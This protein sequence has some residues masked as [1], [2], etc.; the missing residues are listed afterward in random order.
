MQAARSACQTPSLA[1]PPQAQE[2]NTC[3][4]SK[5]RV[6]M[7]AAPHAAS[8]LTPEVPC[9]VLRCVEREQRR[10]HQRGCHERGQRG[11]DAFPAAGLLERTQAGALGDALAAGA[12]QV[13]GLQVQVAC[14]AQ[15]AQERAAGLRGA[16]GVGL[17]RGH[18][19]AAQIWRVLVPRGCLCTRT[20]LSAGHVPGQ[21]Q[22]RRGQPQMHGPAAGPAA[23]P[24]W[25]CQRLGALQPIAGT[26]QD[27]ACVAASAMDGP[28]GAHVQAARPGQQ[29]GVQGVGGQLSVPGCVQRRSSSCPP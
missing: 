17:V 7:T 15:A 10:A 25:S 21:A 12:P 23:A 28:E 16:T 14:G 18:G 9:A 27:R 24:A 1:D 29:A 26:A 4:A 5:H 3:L 13:D 22:A 8:P 2:L 20:T 11:R 6:K 19:H